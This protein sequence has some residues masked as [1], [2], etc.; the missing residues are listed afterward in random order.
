V[1][2]VPKLFDIKGD[3]CGCGACR[4]VCQV[5]AISM[6]DDKGFEYP[7]INSDQCIECEQCVRVCPFKHPPTLEGALERPISYAVKHKEDKVRMKS[8]S[9]GAFTAIAEAL[10]ELG[11]AVIYGAQYDQEFRVV[12]GCVD[13]FIDIQKFRGSKYVQSDIGDTFV[14]ITRDLKEGKWVLFTGTPCQ[15]AG[16]YNYLDCTSID[17]KQFERLIICD[18]VCHGVSSPRVFDDHVKKLKRKYKAEIKSI[19]FRYKPAG[20]RGYNF[21]VD[22]SSD[23]SVLS[24]D[25]AYCMLFGRDYIL[26]PSCFQ[27]PFANTERKS[28]FTIGDFWGIEKHYSTFE[29]DK[30]VSLLLINSQKGLSILSIILA[31][32]DYLETELKKSLQHNLQKPTLKPQMYEDFW[33]D[34][35]E[36]GYDA[37]IRKYTGYG[38]LK[39]ILKNLLVK[40][41]IFEYIKAF[42]RKR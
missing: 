4:L 18:I 7:E 5:S 26:R 14:E 29:D 36:K 25:D 38:S 33:R 24:K 19:N 20:W 13:N 27:C 10:F 1:K 6:R 42:L 15:C 8:S 2:V 28:D 23:K 39:Y 37:V 30:G 12:H 35:F 9:G 11:D 3:C 22:F 21:K 41:G 34:Y 32:M 40:M 31:R 16:L 17:R